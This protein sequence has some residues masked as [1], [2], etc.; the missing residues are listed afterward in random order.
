[1]AEEREIGGTV[2][3]IE[4][5]AAVPRTQGEVTCGCWMGEVWTATIG[6]VGVIRGTLL[7]AISL[8]VSLSNEKLCYYVPRDEPYPPTVAPINQH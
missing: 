8:A 3:G 2:G 6:L 4:R 5:A 7:C 1:M